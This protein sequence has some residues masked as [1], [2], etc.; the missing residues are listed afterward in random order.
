MGVNERKPRLEKVASVAMKGDSQLGDFSACQSLMRSTSQPSIPRGYENMELFTAIV[1]EDE[2]NMTSLLKNKL[3][4]MQKDKQGFTPLLL[5]CSLRKGY[6]EVYKAKK[7]L[8]GEKLGEGEPMSAL[9]FA[10]C[11][12]DCNFIRKLLE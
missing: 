11:A 6:T 9:H 5:A 1:F 7:K 4:F 8:Y 3:S 2:E 12:R 10:C